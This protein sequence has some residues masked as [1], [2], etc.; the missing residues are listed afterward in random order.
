MDSQGEKYL[1]RDYTRSRKKLLSMLGKGIGMS[2]D[3]A[4]TGNLSRKE[5]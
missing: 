4:R 3:A 2:G 1:T 5:I